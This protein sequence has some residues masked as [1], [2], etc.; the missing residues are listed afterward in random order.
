MGQ[1]EI[2]TKREGI[3]TRRH[4]SVRIKVN[5]FV[6]AGIESLVKALNLFPEVLTLDSCEGGS[7]KAAHVFFSIGERHTPQSN[8]R[9][10]L[11]CCWLASELNRH[12]PGV[13]G[14]CLKVEWEYDFNTGMAEL[15]VPSHTIEKVS[16]AIR[17]IINIRRRTV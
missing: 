10:A 16:R 17:S 3:V 2:Y 14:Y 7:R 12:L 15:T 1:F 6:D 4:K 11:F 5:A 13:N 8:R 9:L